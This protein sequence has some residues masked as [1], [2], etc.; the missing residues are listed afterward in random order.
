MAPTQHKVVIYH[1]PGDASVLQVEEQPIPKRGNGE[2]LV[3][4][5]SASVN[6]ID[7]KMRQTNKDQL[8]KV[9][10]IQRGLRVRVYGSQPPATNR[11]V[12]IPGGDVSGIVEETGADSKVRPKQ[13]LK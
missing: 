13:S 3:K 12:Q 6:P 11:F 10:W 2:V 5:Y 4:Q 9:G 1:Q 8:P 7:F